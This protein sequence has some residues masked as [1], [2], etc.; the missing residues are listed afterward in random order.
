MRIDD[1][2]STTV[3]FS[4]IPGIKLW[5]KAVTPPGVDGGGENDTTTMRNLVWRTRSPKK[6]K[7][8]TEMTFTAAYDPAVI[9]QLVQYAN[10]N[11]EITVTFADGSTLTFWGWLNSATPGEVVEGEQPTMDV[12]VIPSNQDADGNEIDPVLVEA[13]TS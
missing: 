7:T 10:I 6:L 3:E 8:L 2:H 5:E 12:S 9:P 1:G 11:Q 4:A 13:S